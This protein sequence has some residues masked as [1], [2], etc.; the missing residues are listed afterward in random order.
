MDIA[1]Y[2]PI[3]NE[4]SPT[5]KAL[6]DN[7]AFERTISSGT[8]VHNGETECLGL[9]IVTS[10]QLRAYKTSEDGRE[11]TLFRLLEYDVCLFSNSCTMQSFR[12]DVTIAAQ[13][14]S[15]IIIIPAHIYEQ[16]S[17]TSLTLVTYASEIMANHFSDVM[18]LLEQIMWKSFDKRLADFLLEESS[19]EESTTL[20]ITHEKIANHLGTAR[21]VVTRMLKYFQ[22][23]N[24]VKLT[25]GTIDIV[26]EE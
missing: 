9:T 4:L 26:D 13:K 12:T 6:I 21:E 22:N 7:N 15:T 16:L 24:L 2:F 10:G 25:R 1:K 17:R 8:I 14:D 20:T 23:E 19:L 11:I 5:E 18:W 3:Y